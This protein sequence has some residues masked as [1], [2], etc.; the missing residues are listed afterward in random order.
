MTEDFNICDNLQDLLFPHHSSISDNLFIIVDLFN[1]ELS[2]FT[3]QVL[4]QYSDNKHNSN[5]IINLMFLCSGS[6]KLDNYSIYPD[7]R[8][9]SDYAHLTIIIPITEEHVISSKHFSEEESIFIKDL[10]NSI[11][12]IDTSNISDIASLDRAVN[13]FVSIV[14]VTWENNLKVINITRHSKSWW[15]KSYSRNLE[16]YRLSKSLED[17]K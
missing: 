7:W 10:T 6:S 16:K 4:T 15:D 5:S 12:N 13:K 2:N 8:L 3:N 17:W 14:E 11:R 1:L 9:L